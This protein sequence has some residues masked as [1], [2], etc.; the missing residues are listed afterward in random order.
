M[1]AFRIEKADGTGVAE[2]FM[3]LFEGMPN[4][5]EDFSSAELARFPSPTCAFPS[6]SMLLARFDRRSLRTVLTAGYTIRPYFVSDYAVGAS[7]QQVIFTRE[8]AR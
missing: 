3:H 5:D 6:R 4:L 8:V 7:G 1:V 2:D